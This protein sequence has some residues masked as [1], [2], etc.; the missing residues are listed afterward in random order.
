[1]QLEIPADGSDE[2]REA[3]VQCRML[4]QTVATGGLLGHLFSPLK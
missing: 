4:G 1:V 3:G 2:P